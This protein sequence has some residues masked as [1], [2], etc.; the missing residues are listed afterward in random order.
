MNIDSVIEQD[1]TKQILLSLIKKPINIPNW[2]VLA[3]PY[4][5]GRKTLAKNFIKSLKCPNLEASGSNCGTCDVCSNILDDKTIFR[6]YDYSEIENIEYA[7]YIMITNFELCPRDIQSKLFNWWNSQ[8]KLPTII[9]ITE[10]TDNF[11]DSIKTISL[12]LRTS[13]LTNR[14][15]VNNLYIKSQKLNLDIPEDIL[16]TIARRSKGHYSLA[17]RLFDKY[18]MLDP[19]LFKEAIMSARE[20][21]I[22]F[23]I[24]CYRDKTEDVDKFLSEL[25]NI[26]L[27]Y[28][29]V[30]YEALIVEIMKTATK[31]AKPKDKLMELLMNEIKTKA[32]D[33]FYIL[34]DKIIYDSFDCDDKFQAAMYVIYQ[35]LNN[36]LR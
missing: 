7:N 29:K 12:I 26:P 15:I 10:H 21:Y 6:T 3:G 4:G 17:L 35:K 11:I 20:Y 8:T 31:H 5:T 19:S 16:D 22:C 25:L 1:L 2:I 33:L 34:N 27:A 13:G 9:L 14:A 23:L 36:R 32:L 24:S 28:L 30:D 18:T